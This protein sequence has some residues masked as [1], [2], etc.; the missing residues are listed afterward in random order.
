MSSYECM[1]LIP[2]QLYDSIAGRAGGSQA[3]QIRQLN[4]IDVHNGGR[5]IVHADGDKN[6]GQTTAPGI[7]RPPRPP[8]LPPPRPP[9]GGSG[10]GCSTSSIGGSDSRRS[11]SNGE[12]STQSDDSLQP[13][14]SEASAQ[15]DYLPPGVSSQTRRPNITAVTTQTDYL[16]PGVST[17]TRRPNITAVSTQTDYIPPGVH[18]QT[19]RPKISAVSTQTD[20]LPP[21]VHSQTRRPKISAVSTQTDYIPPGVGSQAEEQLGVLNPPAVDPQQFPVLPYRPDVAAPSIQTD[22]LPTGGVGSQT[23]EESFLDPLSAF[24]RELAEGNSQ[25]AGSQR[26]ENFLSRERPV[27]FSRRSRKPQKQ[28]QQQRQLQREQQYYR[29]IIEEIA[30]DDDITNAPPQLQSGPI[31]EEITDDDDITNAPP[32]LQSIEHHPW[33]EPNASDPMLQELPSAFDAQQ[34]PLRPDDEVWTGEQ[35]Q[36]FRDWWDNYEPRP[37]RI[38][39]EEEEDETMPSAGRRRRPV[40]T[41]AARRDLL[42]DNDWD[43]RMDAAVRHPRPAA[44]AAAAESNVGKKRKVSMDTAKKSKKTPGSGDADYDF[45]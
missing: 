8:Q 2:K 43:R 7:G 31:I 37:E 25:T 13:E 20:Y 45:W 9:P 10:N 40:A 29:P 18:T 41:L 4:D 44:A 5:V 26:R 22:Y 39:E 1:Y 3:S 15:T 6:V 16:P 30:D 42:P 27:P 23:E 19:R 34:L 17:Q 21:G 32:Q 24:A 38:V 28:Q 36:Q 12:A 33:I 35:Q 11:V 14:L